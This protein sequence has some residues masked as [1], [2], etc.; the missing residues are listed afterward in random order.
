MTRPKNIKELC[1]F[2]WYLENKYDLLDFEIDG[3]KVWQ[4]TRMQL[5]YILAE[6]SG[7]LSQPHTRLGKLDIVK[8]FLSYLKNSLISNYFTLTSKEFMVFSHPR[9]VSING[10]FIDIY[11][12]YLIDDI[13]KNGQNIIEFESAYLGTHL[14]QKQNFTHYTDWIAIS[15]RIYEIFIK[16][17]ISKNNIKVLEKIENEINNIC[18]VKLNLLFFV[19]KSI[20]TYRALYNIYNKIFKK[21]KPKTLFTVVSYGQAP[22]IKA[23]KDNNINVIEIQHGTFSKYHL[24]YSFPNREKLLD[25]FPDKLYLWNDFWKSIIKL[26]LDDQ[27]VI[28]NGFKYLDEQKNKLSHIKKNPYQL[29]VISQGAIG[30]DIATKFLHYYEKFKNYDIKY[31]LHPGEFDRWESYSA[32]KKLSQYNNVDIITNQI[33]L[34]E[35]FAQS[36]LQI[37]VFSTALY[38]GVEFGCDTILLDINGIEY[39]DRFIEFYN[40]SVLK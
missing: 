35:L 37:G 28:N 22:I 30:N 29:I 9:V 24:G 3:V 12:K 14:R 20:K 27:N 1:E 16:V 6:S 19:I 2:I 36:S 21:V 25:Y 11:T 4:Y 40:I 26:P 7:V 18:K 17:K 34:Y 5:Y 31:K 32:L 23:A 38:E 39:M 13:S 8:H 10:E 15:R 33:H